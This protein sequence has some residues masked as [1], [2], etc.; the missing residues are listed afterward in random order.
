MV[1]LPLRQVAEL[2]VSFGRTRRCALA[3]RE[4]VGIGLGQ[5][6]SSDFVGRHREPDTICA[7]LLPE[8]NMGFHARFS[9]WVEI[10]A[11]GRPLPTPALHQRGNCRRLSCRSQL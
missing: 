5:S 1:L 9:E 2:I 7:K 10:S 8:L 3:D 11:G 6:P 4:I